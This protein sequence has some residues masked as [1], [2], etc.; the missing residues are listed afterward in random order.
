[1]FSGIIETKSEVTQARALGSVIEFSIAR[2]KSFDDIA[3]GDSICVDGVCLTVS[4]L[5]SSQLQF[6]IGPETIQVTDWS[7][8]YD[9]G[10]H[11]NLERSLKVGDRIHGHYV[12]GHVD[13][14]G[15]V[16]KSE[17]APGNEANDQTKTW[18]L[19]VALDA[20]MAWAFWRKGSITL[21]GVSLTVNEVK[22]FSGQVIVSVCLIPETL[23]RTNLG[24]LKRGDEIHVEIDQMARALRRQAELIQ[25]S[26][27]S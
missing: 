17:G 23:M 2:P 7:R 12:T 27:R 6:A 1:M 14:R 5:D 13:T 18:L 8:R 22:D 11:V 26:G 9:L 15:V 16:A 20:S 19:D 21:N 4:K 25:P 3:V 10:K 24:S